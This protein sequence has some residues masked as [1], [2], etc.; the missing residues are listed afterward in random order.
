[1]IVWSQARFTSCKS[2]L[3]TCKMGIKLLT[4]CS[5]LSRTN[6]HPIHQD[7]LLTDIASAT[8]YP[9]QSGPAQAET[10]RDVEILSGHFHIF[11]QEDQAGIYRES[12]LYYSLQCSVPESLAV[13]MHPVLELL[14]TPTCPW[15]KERPCSLKLAPGCFC[16]LQ[17]QNSEYHDGHEG[18]QVS[19]VQCLV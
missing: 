17:A 13:W 18:K 3:L 7:L 14:E 9:Q 19:S 6:V 5:C 16:R 15:N 8:R 12:P 11:P 2:Q 10:W 1:M 4:P